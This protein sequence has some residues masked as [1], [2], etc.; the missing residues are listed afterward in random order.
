MNVRAALLC[1]VLAA[2]SLP[3]LERAGFAA[4]PVTMPSAVLADNSSF[5]ARLMSIAPNWQ[6]T[7]ELAGGARQQLAAADLCWW[8]RW[9]EP[10]Q[11]AQT[12]LVDGSLLVGDVTSLNKERVM[13]DGTMVGIVKLPLEDVAGIVVHS[14][15]DPQQADKLRLSLSDAAKSIACYWPAAIRCRVKSSRSTTMH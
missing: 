9:V 3:C 4:T 15:A 12:L 1:A 7:F 10:T 6:L 13:L 8:G 2:A 5:D 11:D 14:P